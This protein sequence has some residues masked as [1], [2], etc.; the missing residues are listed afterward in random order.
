MCNLA[1]ASANGMWCRLLISKW[2]KCHRKGKGSY[3]GDIGRKRDKE[4]E[5]GLKMGC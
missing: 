2:Y 5:V 1:K 4:K 3:L